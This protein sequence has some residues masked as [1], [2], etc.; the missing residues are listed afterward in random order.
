MVFCFAIQYK[1]RANSYHIFIYER[2]DLYTLYIITQN[3][4][5]VSALQWIKILYR[6]SN[7]SSIFVF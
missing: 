2:R 1:S 4:I 7:Y 3:L 6:I 5:R